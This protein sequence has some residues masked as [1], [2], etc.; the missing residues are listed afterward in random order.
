MPAATSAGESVNPRRRLLGLLF[1]TLFLDLAGF[2][3]LFPLGPD[4]LEFYLSRE[5]QGGLLAMLLGLITPLTEAAAPEEQQ[6]L[7]TVLFGGVLTGLYSL[8]QFVAAPL[9]G[10]LSDRFGR[11]PVLLWTI[12]GTALSYLVWIF[13]DDFTLFVASRL[14]AGLMA[15]NITVV[16]A[17]VADV[18]PAK[19]RTRGMAMVGVAFGV[20]FLCGPL[21]GAVASLVDLSAVPGFA[22]LPGIHPFSAA[23]LVA[24]LLA[25][26]NLA[27]VLRALPETR[28]QKESRKLAQ[29]ADTKNASEKALTNSAPRPIG[30]LS[31]AYGL[32]LLAFSGME[33][34]LTFLAHERL[35]YSAAQN[36]MLFLV[37]GIVLIL[38]Q[39]GIVRRLGGKVEERPMAMVGALLA[40]VGLAMLG[41][42]QGLWLLYLGLVFLSA[43]IGLISPTLTALAS[44]FA[45]ADQQG[46]DLGTLRAAGSLA[47]AVGPFLAAWLYWAHGSQVAYLSAALFMLLPGVILLTLPAPPE[48]AETSSAYN[49]RD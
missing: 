5:A 10:L 30:R 8:L 1:L 42:A 39:G 45:P 49:D 35:N 24:F 17:A 6:F 9:W 34:S 2:S 38:V 29:A 11:R 16:T 46:R 43:G 28:P 14:F 47:R 32:F 37:S 27:Q 23:A 26:F 20:G 40:A 18:T 33:F 31:L 25:A 21:I 4:L 7:L 13:A 48:E 15:G 12:G 36:G 3:I 44:R 41:W 22:I 19:E